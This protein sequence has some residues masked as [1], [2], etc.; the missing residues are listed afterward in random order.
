MPTFRARRSRLAIRAIAVANIPAYE[1]LS[2]RRS[3]ILHP[4][5][6]RLKIGALGTIV[7]AMFKRAVLQRLM[8]ALL[9]VAV[10]ISTAPVVQAAVPTNPCDCPSMQMHGQSMG[11]HAQPTQKNVTCNDMQNCICSLS[12]GMSAGLSQQSLPFPPLTLSNK[13][14]WSEPIGGSSL[15]I[16]PSIPPPISVV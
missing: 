1:R 11:N 5:G 10:F 15:S 3:Q 12:C 7:R 16:K 2:R 13:L 6:P 14:A 9:T 4:D 8:V